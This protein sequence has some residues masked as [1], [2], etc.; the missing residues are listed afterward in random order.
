M[1]TYLSGDPFRKMSKLYN[2]LMPMIVTCVLAGSV[3]AILAPLGT[4]QVPTL[5]RFSLWIGLCLVGGFGASIVEIVAK[6]FGWRLKQWQTSIA[7]SFT[8]SIAVAGAMLV[9]TSFLIGMPD[10]RQSLVILFYVWVI[11]ATISGIGLL[12]T[13]SGQVTDGAPARIA[14]YERL[15]PHL[16]SADIYALSAEDHYVRVITARGD[17]LILM[18]L[19]DAVKE[20]SPLK[21]LSPHRSWWVAEAGVDKIKKSE[22]ILHTKQIIA[23][24][25]TG[26]KLVRE[27][28]W[29]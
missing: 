20:T 12:V 25:R 13:K 3:L 18:R 1:P 24:S 15:A 23:I 27:A 10:W 6:A 2:A 4:S 7:Q 17:E 28:G 14:L 21:G 19:S 16:R 5:P 29:K 22:I 11:S 9:L 8:A 26:M